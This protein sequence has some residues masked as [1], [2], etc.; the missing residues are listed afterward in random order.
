MPCLELVILRN[1]ALTDRTRFS[2]IPWL[3]GRIAAPIY[4]RILRPWVS[5][6]SIF[7]VNALPR[8]CLNA[9]GKERT[10]IILSIIALNVVGASVAV[11]GITLVYRLYASTA[12]STYLGT[13]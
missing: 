9:E 11:T 6:S 3:C 5:L 7:D 4:R 8:S 13:L 1:A 10:P 2:T 12:N